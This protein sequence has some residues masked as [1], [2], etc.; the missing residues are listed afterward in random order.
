[1]IMKCIVIIFRIIIIAA[2]EVNNTLVA[3]ANEIAR[4]GDE[5]GVLPMIAAASD[6]QKQLW[7]VMAL[8][9]L[10]SPLAFLLRTDG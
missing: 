5:R 3:A 10:G 9:E 6:P 7:M 8:G 1:M 4:L 2:L